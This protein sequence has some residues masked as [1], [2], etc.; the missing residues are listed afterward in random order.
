MDQ[1]QQLQNLQEQLADLM[2]GSA[3]GASTLTELLQQ[4]L[5]VPGT[6]CVLLR[7]DLP[8]TP[9]G[10]PCHKHCLAARQHSGSAWSFT[11]SHALDHAPAA[12]I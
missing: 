11:L 5:D 7:Q 1:E 9:Q 8:E 2:Q 10:R 3:L 6:R 12:A 4:Q